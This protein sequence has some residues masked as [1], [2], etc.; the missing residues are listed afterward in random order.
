MQRKK[1]CNCSN[2]MPFHTCADG[3]Y[4][5]PMT[6]KAN[7]R[8][9]IS[10]RSGF[11]KT[12][13]LSCGV[14]LFFPAASPKPAGIK[15]IKLSSPIDCKLGED[16][17]IQNYVDM[18]PSEDGKDF[19][20]GPLAYNNHQGTDFRLRNRLA[21]QKPYSALATAPGKVVQVINNR[22]DHGFEEG[23]Y[24]ALDCGNAVMIDHGGG[25]LSQYCHLAEGSVSVKRGDIVQSGQPLGYVGS[26]G[27][28]SYPH[29]HY[30]IRAFG[31]TIDPFIG[32]SPTGCEAA[33]AG[34]LWDSSVDA[35]YAESAVLGFGV[36]RDFPNLDAMENGGLTAAPNEPYA[37]FYVWAHIMGVK[38]GDTLRFLAFAP[39]GKFLA[40]E[41]F[42][43]EE[44]KTIFAAN[45]GVEPSDGDFESWPAGT[46]EGRFAFYRDGQE[47]AKRSANFTFPPQ[48]GIEPA[49]E[50]IKN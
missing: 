26:S 44:E 12:L 24:T 15:P 19:T 6:A 14:I 32:V 31:A 40:S 38:K 16:C 36:T 48:P 34:P 30:A 17:F 1:L 20:C 33:E 2:T 4:D 23:A 21:L 45:I 3:A 22:P 47:I 37:P 18:D 5:D 35:F 8:P 27:G 9:W 10:F 28:T 41:R 39:D 49:S 29:L 25:W 42:E 7:R 13:A 50:V 11:L 43:I 46:Y